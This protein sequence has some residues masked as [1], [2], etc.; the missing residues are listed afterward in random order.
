MA[1]ACL[2][3]ESLRAFADGV[4]PMTR[5]QLFVNSRRNEYSTNEMRWFLM[6]FFTL[7][8]FVAT[9]AISTTPAYCMANSEPATYPIYAVLVGVLSVLTGVAATIAVQVAALEL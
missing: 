8:Q 4:R 2:G 3:P 9:D 5:Q 6:A 7:T 1:L